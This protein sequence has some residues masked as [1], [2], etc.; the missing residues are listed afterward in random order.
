MTEAEL[1]DEVMTL[2]AA[3]HE[4]T[5]AALAW[6]L[7]L[8]AQHPHTQDQLERELEGEL[9]GAAPAYGDLGRLAMTRMILEESM[10]LYP[11][12]WSI[13]RQ[14]IADDE[15]GGHRIPRH[16][17]LVL[18]PYVMHRLGRF[19]DD[20]DRFDPAR[21]A[22]DVIQQRPK[23][24]YFPFGAA[25]RQCA[26]SRFSMVEMQLILARTVQRFRIELARDLAVQPLAGLTLTPDR[27]LWLS[28]VPRPIM[29]RGPW[30]G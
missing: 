4:T 15:I 24:V 10:R 22:P 30:P 17:F 13:P 25:A 3:G 14:A 26:G 6:T 18:S 9:A 12:V 2:F 21:F 28:L 20:P 8:L 16:S 11:P 5:A 23:F 7:L 1:L 27:P 19:W 29:N